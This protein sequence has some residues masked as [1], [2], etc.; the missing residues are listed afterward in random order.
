MSA[1]NAAKVLCF[2]GVLERWRLFFRKRFLFLS[3]V[4]KSAEMPQ[5]FV[6]KGISNIFVL[7]FAFVLNVSFLVSL[8]LSFW[9]FVFCFSSCFQ[10]QVAFP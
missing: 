3:F 1:A 4:A 7:H 8:P 10:L 2:T 5:S 9:P 6:Q